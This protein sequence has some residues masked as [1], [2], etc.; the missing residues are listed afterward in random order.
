[1]IG[2]LPEDSEPVPS[3]SAPP[4]DDT[5]GSE[6]IPSSRAAPLFDPPPGGFV[7]EVAVS[8]TSAA[9]E[10]VVLACTTTPSQP[11]TP[12][13]VGGPLTL[14]DSTIL[15]AQVDTDWA[16]GDPV[17]ASYVEISP[18]IADFSSNLPV[19]V[20]WTDAFAPAS[21]MPV[22]LGLD[23]FEPG[24]GRSHLTDP[25]TE[26]GRA[27]LHTRGRSTAGVPKPS[28]DLE[29]WQP[30]SEADRPVALLGMPADG[31]WILQAPY[32]YDES[33][34]RNA[35]G[36]ALSNRIGRYAPRTR[37]A[38]VFVAGRGEAVHSGHYLGVYAVT[39]EIERGPDRI[40]VAP[41][42]PEDIAEP[43]VTGGY[44]FKRDRL[45]DGEV[46][47]NVGLAGGAFS[48]LDPLVWV[49]PAEDEVVP[50]QVAYLG[51]V[52]DELAWALVQPDFTNPTT[53]RHYSE[54][55]D[56]DAWIDH[57][58]LNVLI[59]NPDAF[60]LSGYLSKD[61][62]GPIVAGPLWD[63]DR[64]AGGN[65]SRCQD[66][67]WWDAVNLTADTTPFFSW[68]WYGALFEDPAFRERYWA[69]WN[70]LL[71]GD[72]ALDAVLG[73]IDALAEPL[74]EAAARNSEVW[75]APEFPG[76]VEAL[77]Q[78][79]RARHAWIQACLERGGDPRECR[80]G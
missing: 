71:A 60:R 25:A 61:R 37:F 31:D 67:T 19:L 32:Y 8:I 2:P 47:M 69:R 6:H 41:I 43:E 75:A 66:P 7:G 59:K 54:I 79:F 53:G 74:P 62:E 49:D 15:I 34:I 21:T 5:G 63:L 78:W 51:G 11:C 23:L 73:E 65:D 1:M 14:T 42:G 3:D 76:Q 68:A 55:I 77:K 27:R 64:T 58:I 28:Y 38:E 10:G 36:F 48:F 22:A 9:G 44:V 50:A 33:L 45:G 17:A 40:D 26:A 16:T 39:E 12:A 70:D 30:D 52:V 13:P 80:G 46:G 57:H 72:L 4:G 18:E 20:F 24:Q 35:L 56:V 29:L